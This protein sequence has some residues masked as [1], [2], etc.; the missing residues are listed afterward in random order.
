MDFPDGYGT[1][2]GDEGR[3]LSGGQ[4]QVQDGTYYLIDRPLSRRKVGSRR[5]SFSNGIQL[6][7]V[8]IG[9]ALLV[10]SSVLGFATCHQHEH[11]REHQHLA[12]GTQQE[13]CFAETR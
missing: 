7:A 13:L 6:T 8:G 10:P 11:E 9:P 3:Q 4:K 12:G 2:V 5:L 1:R